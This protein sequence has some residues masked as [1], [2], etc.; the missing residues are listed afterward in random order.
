MFT[1]LMKYDSEKIILQ[2]LKKKMDFKKSN[3]VDKQ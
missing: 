1:K 3:L 2:I